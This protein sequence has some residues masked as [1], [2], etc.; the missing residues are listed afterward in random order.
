[1]DQGGFFLP[2]PQ[3]PPSAYSKGN[4]SIILNL[5]LGE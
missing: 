5:E 3:F 4:T 1:L 2:D